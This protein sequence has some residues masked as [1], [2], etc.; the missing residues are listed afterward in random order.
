MAQQLPTLAAPPEHPRFNSQHL[1]LSTCNS[2]S[3]GSDTSCTCTV[4][5]KKK[6]KKKKVERN[7]SELSLEREISS[8]REELTG[9]KQTTQH[10]CSTLFLC[11]TCQLICLLETTGQEVP[12]HMKK[13][14]VIADQSMDS[15]TQDSPSCP[16]GEPEFG[17]IL[18]F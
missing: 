9:H 17:D 1:Q 8:R 2:L 12:G 6:K 13:K 18:V 10:L 11:F 4:G 3:R 16:F 15:R 7:Q 14:E 5:K